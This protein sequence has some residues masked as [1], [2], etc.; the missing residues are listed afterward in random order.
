MGFSRLA[1]LGEEATKGTTKRKSRKPLGGNQ[2]Y[3][4]RNWGLKGELSK[5]KG[6][7]FEEKKKHGEKEKSE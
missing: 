2:G 1:Y 4:G 6:V 3:M 7:S 5:R